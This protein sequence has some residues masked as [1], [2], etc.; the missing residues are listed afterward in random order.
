MAEA[1]CPR[2]WP[3]LCP[4]QPGLLHS[5]DSDRLFNRVLAAICPPLTVLFVAAAVVAV[6]ELATRRGGGQAAA[7]N[8]V[9]VVADGVGDEVASVPLAGPEGAVLIVL[10]VAALVVV[11]V[12]VVVVIVP[13]VL[14]LTVP[15]TTAVAMQLAPA[16]RLCDGLAAAFASQTTSYSSSRLAFDMLRQ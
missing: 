3:A 6:T 2:E 16:K 4:Q 1:A 12:A 11:V 7:T 15:R 9:A 8:R 14:R 5:P 13:V 10:A